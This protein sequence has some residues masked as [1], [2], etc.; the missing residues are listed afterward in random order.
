M[1]KVL[2]AL[3]LLLLI[4]GINLSAYSW[5]SLIEF[6]D[7][8]INPVTARFLT[9][10][11]SK[12][13][14][15]GAECL[16]IRLD[17]PGG[18]Q[19]S[20]ESMY[21]AILNSPLPIVVYVAPEGAQA[22]SAGVFIALSAHITAMA[23]TTKIGSAHP[24]AVGGGQMDEDVKNKIVEHTVA[25][26]KKIAETRGRNIEW[27]EKAVRDS[28]SSTWTEALDQ[29][30]IDL[31][32]Y[33]LNELLEKIDGRTVVTESG[34]KTLDTKKADIRVVRMNLRDRLLN[35]I[36]DPNIAYILLILGFYGLFFE[37]SNP[38][39]VF[40]GVVGAICIILAFFALQT[41]PVN[42][43][44]LLLILL[45]IILFILEVKIT[46]YGLLS[47][48]GIVS[49]LIGSI[50]LIDSAE[51]FA[52]IFKISWQIILPAVL[53]TAG[54]FIFGMIMV[55][56]THRKKAITG[57]EGLLGTVGI[58]E[59]E[60]NPEGKIFL[61]GEFW[62]S[63]SDEVILP[64]EKVRVIGYEGLTLK[65]EKIKQEGN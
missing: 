14:E 53:V 57:K 49:M 50:M 21:K 54:F 26:V 56:R 19:K 6:D 35:I 11:I 20:M 24:V 34:E 51:P 25:E 12:A 60:I 17:T 3:V 48:G 52:Y 65:V 13:Y 37:L 55:I 27:A 59:T 22:T 36:S 7:L 63:V 15:E 46:S 45:A 61:H 38:G 44:G 9:R 58:C 28:I 43:A 62:K 64:K 16:I 39:S 40:P 42:Y 2:F 4:C 31:I 32:A 33:D 30:V 1:K 18:L 10:T 29:N 47:M 41:L 23:P 8:I 5:V